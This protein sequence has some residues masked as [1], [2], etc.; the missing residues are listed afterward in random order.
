MLYGICQGIDIDRLDI[1][2]L[3][4]EYKHL[5]DFYDLEVSVK[6]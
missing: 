4:S 3:L 2:Y 5:A 1:A 6:K